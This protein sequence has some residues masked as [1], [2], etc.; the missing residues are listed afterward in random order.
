LRS[1]NPYKPFFDLVTGQEDFADYET[2]VSKLLPTWP[3]EVLREWLYHEEGEPTYAFLGFD[4][5]AF[6][7]HAWPLSRIPGREVFA[8]PVFCDRFSASFA[9]RDDW[10]AE[11]MREHG[12]WNTPPILLLNDADYCFPDGDPLRAPV[13]L[14]EGHRRLSFL[15]ALRHARTA[16][17]EHD[18]WIVTIRLSVPP[19]TSEAK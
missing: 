7:R 13:H 14:L 3:S 19:R 12:T 10:L 6:S 1:P 4:R 11:Y 9:D 17:P 8:D 18:V 16:G 15:N 2:R 5:M